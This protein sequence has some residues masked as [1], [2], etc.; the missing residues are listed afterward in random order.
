MS[1]TKDEKEKLSKIK[2][3]LKQN[4]S[5]EMKANARD[6]LKEISVNPPKEGL[7]FKV[8]SSITKLLH[9]PH[10]PGLNSHHYSAL[11]K[12]YKR[13]IWESYAEN[14]CPGAY[15][16]FWYFGDLEKQITIVLII[17]HP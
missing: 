17:P 15:R 2:S 5:L 10:Y 13:K 6:Q 11:D 9:N 14:H 8:K 12:K 16:I 1:M 3:E 7:E 4:H